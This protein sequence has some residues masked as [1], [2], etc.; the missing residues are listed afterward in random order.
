MIQ[1]NEGIM[2]IFG[3]SGL[4][5]ILSNI[6]QLNRLPSSKLLL[7]GFYTLFAGWILTVLEGFLLRDFL[8]YLEHICYC[9]SA[10]FV[11]SWCWKIRAKKEKKDAS[12][13]IF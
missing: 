10:L 11:A 3:L 9:I 12:N 8:N 1:E 5:F 4:F 6:K 13:S 2:L 7:T